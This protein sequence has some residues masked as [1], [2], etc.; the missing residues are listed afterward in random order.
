MP[1]VLAQFYRHREVKRPLTEFQPVRFSSF[2]GEYAIMSNF[3]QIDA[4]GDMNHAGC[5][6]QRAWRNILQGRLP[7]GG[8][9]ILNRDETE[10][11]TIQEVCLLTGDKKVAKMDGYDYLCIEIPRE[12]LVGRQYHPTNGSYTLPPSAANSLVAMMQEFFKFVLL[13]WVRQERRFCNV[14][15]INLSKRNLTMMIDHFFYYYDICMGTNGK[16]R[17]S[18]RRM[19]IRWIDEIRM[20]PND[21]VDFSGADDLEYVY[22]SEKEDKDEDLKDLLMKLKAG[23]KK[24]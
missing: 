18:M 24:I 1:T 16:D 19:A 14:H 4:G 20:L 11:P 6:S 5:F 22:A 23:V 12:V 8:K 10:W 2:Q 7:T 13:D 17:E 21:R 15:G 3:L 9:R